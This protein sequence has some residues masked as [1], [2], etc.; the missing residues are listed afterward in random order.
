MNATVPQ[1]T[2][3]F[4]ALAS[5]SGF[6]AAWMAMMATRYFGLS[7][8]DINGGIG[9]GVDSG[10]W[11]S[12][13]YSA[14]E[15]IGVVLGCWLSIGL[16]IR[17]VLMPAVALFLAATMLPTVV[18]GFPALLLS[19]GLTGL[20]AGAI[21]PLSIL[22]QLRAFGPARR[23]LAIAIYACS[24]T[25]GPQLAACI[26]AWGVQR[27]DWTAVLWASLIP[28][29][30][31]LATGVPGLWREPV[32]WRPLVRADVAGLVSVSAGMGLL[33]C[34]VSQGDRLRW[35]QSPAVPI[36]IVAAG[37]CLVIFVIHELRQSRHPIV[38]LGLAWRWNLLLGALCTIPLQFA[39]IFSGTIVPSALTQLQD[40][41]PEQIAPALTAAFWPQFLSYVAGVIF[42]Q[43]RPMDTRALLVAGL[44]AVALGC[45]FDL[46]ITSDWIV[47]NL[48]IGQVLQG[49]GL[50]LI[51]LSLLHI[52]V[53]EVTPLE[54]AYAASIFNFSRSLSSTIATAWATTSLRL[55]GEG[56]YAELLSNTGF[57]P[58]GH[59]TTLAA[60]ASH[61]AHADPDTMR[62]HLQAVQ[63]VAE[64]A[65]RQASVLAVSD[66]LADLG[67]LL[68][69]SC[70]LV[71]LM[72]ELGSGHPERDKE[73]HR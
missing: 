67:W 35:F 61:I 1:P 43:R 22:V 20:A 21:M 38:S 44:S 58:D 52:Y 13:A 42:L 30:V 36:L 54:G 60:I 72:A 64:A 57:Y 2:P 24:T 47:D 5:I 34:A 4:P 66:T 48:Y 59:R 39:T 28:G 18:P 33:A 37:T 46:T 32:R 9:V 62:A 71:I 53:G 16:S 51:I 25:M 65:R 41:R 10:S 45:C 14:L 15:P 17:R 6:S 31:S 63:I 50:P 68:V 3:A 27:Y 26:G 23:P 40:F 7:A 19:R 29:F 69:A 56:K 73:P 55:H 70:V 11:L 8:G 12:T 49:I